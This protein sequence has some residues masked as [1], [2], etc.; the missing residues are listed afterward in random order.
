MKHVL[1]AALAAAIASPAALAQNTPEE[2]FA[3]YRIACAAERDL[4]AVDMHMSRGKPRK[5]VKQMSA[6]E[7]RIA[8]VL[9]DTMFWNMMSYTRDQVANGL[10]KDTSHS[11]ATTC[12][13]RVRLAQI[14]RGGAQW[15]YPH[16]MKPVD[17]ARA[18]YGEGEG[19]PW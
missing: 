6:E 3:D 12:G 10:V 17:E 1:I 5:S 8:Y 13:Y 11:V 4:T 7:L 14:D 2:A 9:A 15:P 18:R 19:R 16:A